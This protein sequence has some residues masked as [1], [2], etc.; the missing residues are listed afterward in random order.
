MIDIFTLP[1][2]I[3]VVTYQI[4]ALKSIHVAL[5]VKGGSLAENQGENG[6]AHFMEHM[7][8]QGTKSF[9]SAEELSFYVENL[10]GS[11]NAYTDGFTVSFTITLP[12]TGLTDC[13]KIASEVFFHAN[14]PENTIEKERQAIVTEIAQRIDSQWY[15]LDQVFKDTRYKREILQ[16]DT[17]GTR[18]DVEK[19]TKEHMIAYWEKYFVPNNTVLFIGGNFE[20]KELKKLLNEYFVSVPQEQKDV[21]P[22]PKIT[23]EDFNEKGIFLKPNPSY[24]T[25]YVDISF[26][27]V[28][29]TAD[30]KEL[31]KQ[32]IALSLLGQFRTSRLF[33]LLRYKKGLVYGVYAQKTLYPEVGLVH[34][35]YETPTES[36]A[37]VTKLTLETLYDF[38]EKGPTEQEL[39]FA[40]HYFTNSWLMTFDNPSSVANWFE[41]ALLW[42]DTVRTPEDYIE[43]VKDISAKDV[44]EFMKKNWDLSK[45]QLLIQG[46]IEDS[47][48]NREGFDRLFSIFNKG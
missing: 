26:A 42:L 40:K 15:K 1:N 2:G 14:F 34:I 4:K 38:I 18:E 11:Y 9:N 23:K 45:L 41:A 29:Y 17:G 30:W 10:A 33:T 6:V 19:I 12:Y 13:I 28:G 21:Q 16:K 48:E 46:A 20:T 43:M 39:D 32:D 5:A 35:T 8:V 47:V 31:T 37:E 24:S 36:L 27:T 22:Y 44:T 25:N 3:R 7:L